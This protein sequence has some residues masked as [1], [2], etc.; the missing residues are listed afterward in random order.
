MLLKELIR[1]QE[2]IKLT[3]EIKAYKSPVALFGLSQTARAAFVAAVQQVTERQVVVLTKDEKNANRLNEDI[4]FFNA[5]SQ[6]FPARDLTLRPL[7]GFSREFEY[8][9]IKTM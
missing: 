1:T 7:E 9:R 8:R 3:N 5:K 6:V 4:L 2:F